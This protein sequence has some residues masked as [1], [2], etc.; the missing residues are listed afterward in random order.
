MSVDL[1]FWLTDTHTT[2]T[3]RL[4]GALRDKRPPERGAKLG[5]SGAGLGLI[6]RNVTDVAIHLHLLTRTVT[7]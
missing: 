1:P 6:K 2:N 7:H 4:K 3:T 5:F